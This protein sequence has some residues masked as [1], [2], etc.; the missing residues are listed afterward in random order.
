MQSELKQLVELVKSIQTPLSLEEMVH[1]VANLAAEI[2]NVNKVTIRV[3]D[4]T[5]EN[6]M[7]AARAG[8]PIHIGA[9]ERFRVGEGLMG[10]VVENNEAL[11]LANAQEDKRFL[12]RP[13]MISQIG[14]Y[15]GAPLRIGPNCMGVLS[16][17]SPKLD[18]FSQ[19]DEDLLVLV[20]ALS[21]PYVE[22][23]RLH[24]LP[25]VKDNNFVSVVN[26]AQPMSYDEG[27][28]SY[29]QFFQSFLNQHFGL[30]IEGRGCF[31]KHENFWIF[32]QSPCNSYSLAFSSGEL[33]SLFTNQSIVTIRQLGNKL[34]SIGRF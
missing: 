34:V 1:V 9:A 30:V 6:L 17:V 14:S 16:A 2:L 20:A 12:P 28:A 32:K 19:I 10:W 31:I 4:S 27:G 22:I 13:G 25:L 7:V 11:R 23:A 29:H 15:L 26:G 5:N 3:L 8:T 24:H 18:A 33:H 21:G